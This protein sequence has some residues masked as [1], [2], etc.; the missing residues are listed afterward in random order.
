MPASLELVEYYLPIN[1]LTNLDISE[2]FPEWSIEKIAS[3]TGINQRHIASGD[4]FTSDLAIG[5]GRKLLNHNNI[6]PSEID[7]VLLCTQSPDYFLPTTA[8]IVQDKLGI[9]TSAGALDINLGCSGYIYSLGIAK[10]LIETGQAKNVML[11]TSD[12]YTKFINPGDKSVRTIFGDA[13]S[14]SLVSS[15]AQKEHLI[16]FTYGTDG[17]GAKHLIVPR[18]GLRTGEQ[19]SP[20]SI[21]ERSL[22]S[23]NGFDLFMDG[24]EIF[25]FTIEAVPVALTEILMKSNLSEE[26]VDLYIFHQANQFMLQHLRKTLGIP[27]DKFFISM[28]ETG[29]TV[30]S[31]I[32]IAISNAIK[33]GKLQR[34]MKVVLLGFGVGLS[35]AG[36]VFEY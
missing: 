19:I 35:W 26:D 5:A 13:A 22:A 24:P 10:G 12:T 3:K 8:C 6:S 36:C 4:E 27:E 33:N 18:G 14:A 21:E 34:G 7:F 32:P 25:N 16:G 1:T 28:S 23:S 2:Q 31:T 11:I 20:K 15:K 9:P 17:S 30:S 29:N